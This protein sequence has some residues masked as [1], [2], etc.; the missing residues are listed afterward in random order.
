MMY[1]TGLWNE[2]SLSRNRSQNGTKD[3]WSEH[4]TCSFCSDLVHTDGMGPPF[5]FLARELQSTLVT[6]MKM[7]SGR[8]IDRISGS[9]KTS[10][11]RP[12]S[13]FTGSR[14]EAAGVKSLMK[15]WP[16]RP[17]SCKSTCFQSRSVT[18]SEIDTQ[19]TE[20]RIGGLQ[21]CF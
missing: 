17:T 12:G 20:W 18:V 3:G 21:C 8:V 14:Q 13:A 1:N 11:G 19:G 9:E 16:Q 4:V 2:F 10:L 15:G 6:I 5:F 7:L